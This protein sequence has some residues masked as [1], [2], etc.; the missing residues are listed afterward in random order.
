LKDVYPRGVHR[1]KAIY[2]NRN[3]VPGKPPTFRKISHNVIAVEAP[4]HLA[5][6]CSGDNSKFI[7]CSFDD[8]HIYVLYTE[9]M[10]LL[11]PLRIEGVEIDYI[12]GVCNGEI[13]VR[14]KAGDNDHL[15]TARL[16]QKY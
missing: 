7:Y 10:E 4:T 2:M 8:E 1:T 3:D 6:I 9:M 11:P 13:T 12:A 15:V 5:T 16:P 14:D